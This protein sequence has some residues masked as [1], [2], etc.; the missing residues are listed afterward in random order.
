[1]KMIAIGRNFP[2]PT[3]LDRSLANFI[4]K[5]RDTPIVL[6]YDHKFVIPPT[7]LISVY[8]RQYYA[9]LLKTDAPIQH[10][11]FCFVIFERCFVC[12]LDFAS[13]NGVER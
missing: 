12:I 7:R 3:L 2:P 5:D 4:G 1:M 6:I 11:S 10:L 8:T 9:D 13:H